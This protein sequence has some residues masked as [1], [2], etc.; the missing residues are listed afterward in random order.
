MSLS[1]GDGCFT[2]LGGGERHFL[3]GSGAASLLPPHHNTPT[4]TTAAKDANSAL[5]A[6]GGERVGAVS[7]CPCLLTPQ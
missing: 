4:T 1:Y 3:R 2:F 7:S 6:E 5:I